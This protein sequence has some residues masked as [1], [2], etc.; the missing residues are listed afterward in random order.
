MIC[1]LYMWYDIS[2]G[3]VIKCSMVDYICVC[4][5]NILLLFIVCIGI[6]YVYESKNEDFLV[7][8]VIGSYR[9]V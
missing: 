8:I 5:C 2:L 4:I 9:Y 1:V 3:S 7:V 6:W